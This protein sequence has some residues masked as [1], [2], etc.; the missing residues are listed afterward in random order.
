[1]WTTAFLANLLHSCLV[2][3]SCSNNSRNFEGLQNQTTLRLGL[4]TYLKNLRLEFTEGIRYPKYV[5]PY[6]QFLDIT[7]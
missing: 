1:M 4:R 7:N 5:H 2:L 6:W 3:L